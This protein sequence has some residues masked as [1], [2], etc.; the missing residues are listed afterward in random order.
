[1]DTGNRQTM[2]ILPIHEYCWLIK[3]SNAKL[4][5][6]RMDQENPTERGRVLW[7]SN[8]IGHANSNFAVAVLC[9]PQ[10]C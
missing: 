4:Q 5:I 3:P 8:K 6:E 2:T 7:L 1:M 10:V 9:C